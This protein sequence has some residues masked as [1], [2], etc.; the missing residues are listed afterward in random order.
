MHSELIEKP[1]IIAICGKSAAG[2]DSLARFLTGYFKSFGF[3]TNNMIS[4]TTRP[5]RK[6]EQDGYDYFFISNSKFYMMRENKEL[7]ESSHFRGWNYGVPFTSVKPGY[8]NIGVFNPEG[9]HSLQKY[10]YNY[11]IVPVYI[12]EKFWTRMMRSRIREGKWRLEFFRR[13]WTD[14][15]DFEKLEKKVNLSN[16]RWIHLNEVEGVWRQAN[17]IKDEMILWHIF[18]R[19]KETGRLRLGNFI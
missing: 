8:I 18:E 1:I 15:F 17:I 3:F 10:K 6:N 16:G 14:H 4:V 13:A 19:D 12:Q 11:T 5:K 7:I 2:K 9:L